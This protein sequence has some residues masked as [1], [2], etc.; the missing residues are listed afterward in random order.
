MW[1]NI[2]KRDVPVSDRRVENMSEWVDLDRPIDFVIAPY[3]PGVAFFL[4]KTKN[5]KVNLPILKLWM[6]KHPIKNRI[7]SKRWKEVASNK[8]SDFTEEEFMKIANAIANLVNH[9]YTHLF[10][11]TYASIVEVVELNM[12]K[13]GYSSDDHQTIVA[14]KIVDEFFSYAMMGNYTPKQAMKLAYDQAANEW[15]RDDIEPESLGA[16]SQETRNRELEIRQIWWEVNNILKGV[17]DTVL[18]RIFK[19]MG[20]L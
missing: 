20:V 3:Y 5:I 14:K 15:V 19:S 10:T 8:N 13:L 18:M 12:V 11:Q 7:R 4:T 1:F 6:Q 17:S 16:T 9:E 2:I